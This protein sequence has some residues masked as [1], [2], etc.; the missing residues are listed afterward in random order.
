M[1]KV[2]LCSKLA[3]RPSSDL[4]VIPFFAEEEEG[5]KAS[6]AVGDLKTPVE[7]ALSYEDFSGKKGSTLLMLDGGDK[8]ERLLFLGLGS[9]KKVTTQSLKQAVAAFMKRARGKKHWKKVNIVLPKVK[10]MTSHDTFKACLEGFY[11]SSYIFE[12]LKSVDKREPFFLEKVTFIGEG[13]SEQISQAAKVNIG[14]S[15]ARDLVNKNAKDACPSYL[16]H[17]CKQI[18]VKH[19]KVKTSVL[20]KKDLEAKKMGLIL[21][22]G[23]SSADAPRIITMEYRN[24]GKQSTTMVVGKGVTYDTGGLNLKPTGAIEDM[25]CDMGGA[26]AVIGLMKA[27]A[28]QNLKVNLIGVVPTTENAIDS[29]S[30][31]PGDVYTSYKGTTVEI[32]NTDA[33]G[34]LILADALAYGQKKFK[35]DRVIDLATLTGAVVV[36]LGQERTGYY[37]T[38][39]T[40]AKQLEKA[41]L[42][43]DEKIW[44]MPLDE[45]YRDHLKSSI[46]DMANCGRKRMAGSV[47]AAMFLKEFIE[48]GMPW[49]HLDIAG[50]AYLDSPADYHLTQATGAGVRLLNELLLS[51]K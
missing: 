43:S 4:T 35:P 40:F 25:K 19:S 47:T 10:G 48:E 51:L 36:A 11:L 5:V 18:A 29:D 21:A 50:S 28:E 44:R 38:N 27:V 41:S 2:A 39:D 46:A 33:E 42:T 20:S 6:F 22:V 13:T 8:D 32:T 49:V 7:A 12:E 30:Y 16:E 1:M 3:S 23:A 31:K 26:A 24:G 14:V 37:C 9:S 45:E 17:V 15:L 34:R